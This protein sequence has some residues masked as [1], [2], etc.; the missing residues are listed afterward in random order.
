MLASM[1]TDV[2]LTSTIQMGMAENEQHIALKQEEDYKEREMRESIRQSVAEENRII[3]EQLFFVYHKHT[4]TG[5]FNH[6]EIWRRYIGNEFRSKIWVKEAI[7]PSEL[8]SNTKKYTK[9]VLINLSK[10]T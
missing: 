9:W 6:Y 7:K 8:E 2:P 5:P 3:N 4:I 10:E 1:S